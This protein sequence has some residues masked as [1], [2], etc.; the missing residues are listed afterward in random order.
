ML[1]NAIKKIKEIKMETR[2]IRQLDRY[3]LENKYSQ[4]QVA[5]ILGVAFSTVNRWFNG[6]TKPG[7]ITRYHIRKLLRSWDPGYDIKKFDQ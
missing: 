6:K 2:L 5:Y 1:Y 3:R 4:E 7:H